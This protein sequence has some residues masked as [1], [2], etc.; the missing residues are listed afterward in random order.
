M[1]SYNI[2]LVNVAEDIE[3]CSTFSCRD[4]TDALIKALEIISRRCQHEI[5]GK[6]TLVDSSNN[7]IALDSFLDAYGCPQVRFDPTRRDVD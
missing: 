7:V 4:D 3:N 1:Q 6:H 2:T 5:Y